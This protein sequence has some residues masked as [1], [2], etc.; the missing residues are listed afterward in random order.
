VDAG[1]EERAHGLQAAYEKKSESSHQQ[2]GGKS[3]GNTRKRKKIKSADIRIPWREKTKTTWLTVQREPLRGAMS[4][5]CL[6]EIQTLEKE[7]SSLSLWQEQML[8][9]L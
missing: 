7:E 1:T 6:Q 8:R 3:F 9:S 5:L 4:E 2:I